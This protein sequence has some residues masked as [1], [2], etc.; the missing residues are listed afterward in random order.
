[1]GTC[2][3]TSPNTPIPAL[4]SSGPNSAG[5]STLQP[6]GPEGPALP[7]TWQS[8]SAPGSE[9]FS[10]FPRSKNVMRNAGVVLVEADLVAIFPSP[11]L[12]KRELP[13]ARGSQPGV[14]SEPQAGEARTDSAVSVA[15]NR[16]QGLQRCPVFGKHQKHLKGL[17]RHSC[18]DPIPRESDSAGLGQGPLIC[19]SSKFPGMLP[20][21]VRA[22]HFEESC[23]TATL[24]PS[25]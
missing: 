24:C 19:I 16:C 14:D 1:M 9:Y 22:P 17:L 5:H 3:P 20:L 18:L 12:H 6:T 7:G 25:A 2:F 8:S 10:S 23:L 4:I 21:L 11:V 13:A 15:G